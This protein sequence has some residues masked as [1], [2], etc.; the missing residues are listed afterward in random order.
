[1]DKYTKMD[2]K[3]SLI[4]YVN[5]S[6][7]EQGVRKKMDSG[8]GMDYYLWTWV[9]CNIGLALWSAL[10][11]NNLTNKDS[12]IK[13]NDVLQSKKEFCF[14]EI[15]KPLSYLKQTKEHFNEIFH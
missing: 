7:H 1:M 3:P 10:K 15:K 5:V 11:V 13:Q 12:T 2:H 14:C 9:A 8:Y 4:S 6:L